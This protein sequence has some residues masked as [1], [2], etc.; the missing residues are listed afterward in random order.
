MNVNEGKMYFGVYNH[1][2]I[3]IIYINGQCDVVFVILSR[4]Y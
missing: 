2:A 3:N 1:Q 4:L